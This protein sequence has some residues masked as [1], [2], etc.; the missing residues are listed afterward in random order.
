MNKLIFK[1]LITFLFLHILSCKNQQSIRI[2]G[3]AIDAKAG[4]LIETKNRLYYI[5]GLPEWPKNIKNK[6]VF[7]KGELYIQYD[8]AKIDT[9][10]KYVA[11]SA[12][13][14]RIIKSPKYRVYLVGFKS[15]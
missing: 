3:K 13:T 8:T 7:A 12:G 1:I 5:D 4:A 6:K 15:K 14:M 11:Q 2:R 9:S 10:K